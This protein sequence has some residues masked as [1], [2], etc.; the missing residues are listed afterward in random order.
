MAL[1]FAESSHELVSLADC[2]YCYGNAVGVQRTVFIVQNEAEGYLNIMICNYS[3]IK[4]SFCIDT[5][6]M[7]KRDHWPK[8]CLCLQDIFLSSSINS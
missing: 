6:Y 7:E 1:R 4:W 8:I 3:V 5:V 2:R